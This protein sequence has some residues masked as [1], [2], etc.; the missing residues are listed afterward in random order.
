MTRLPLR[1]GLSGLA[2]AFLLTGA[3]VAQTAA[4]PAA[5]AP[6][7]A[8][9][10]PDGGQR[11]VQG[12]ERHVTDLRR[13]LAITPAQQ[14]Q[15]DAF[16]GVMRQNAQRMQTAYTGRAAKAASMSAVD[17]IRSYA[18]LARA[19]ADDLQRL[20]TPF[21]ALYASMSPEQKAAADKVFQQFQTRGERRRA[22]RG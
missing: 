19:H 14:T 18:E 5:P 20:V 1:R 8:T 17:D 10:A 13:R 4:P 9:P 6:A 11:A 22:Q 16:A 15:W 12:V 3:A 7:I 21:E 2:A